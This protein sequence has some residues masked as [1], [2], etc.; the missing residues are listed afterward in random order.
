M[1][2]LPP[3]VPWVRFPDVVLLANESALKRHPEYRRAKAGDFA[4]AAKL[5]KELTGEKGIAAVRNLLNAVSGTGVPVLASAHAREHQGVNAI[6][7]ALAELLRG[8]LR[9]AF[10]TAVVQANIVSHTGATGYGRLARQARFT[11][12]V[13]G[14]CEYLLVDDFVG[15]GG[16]LANLR[17]WIET[18]RG[19][20]VGA[21]ALSGK[22]HSA[23]LQ[24]S[25]EQLNELR[26]RH[27]KE[28]ENWWRERFGHAFD[29]LTKSEARY[30]IRSSDAGTIR[31]RL[32]DEEQG[33]D[34]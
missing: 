15:Q 22:P 29:C 8:F 7:T 10:E 31:D 18:Q 30:L 27:G 20:V 19:R 23:R 17:G 33:R 4:A 6:P 24:P 32:A 12:V 9:L 13:K 5:V 11:G 34:L 26:Q 3:R 1:K 28:L 16:T 2:L 21:V 14:D 25:E